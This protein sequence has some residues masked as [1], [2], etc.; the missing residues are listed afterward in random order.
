MIDP[1]SFTRA[2][3][4]QFDSENWDDPGPQYRDPR[5]TDLFEP[6]CVECEAVA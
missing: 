3:L 4:D 5:Q 6:M 2:Y 1:M